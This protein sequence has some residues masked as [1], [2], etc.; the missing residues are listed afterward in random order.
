MTLTQAF[1]PPARQKHSSKNIANGFD[2]QIRANKS[3]Q[4]SN[5]R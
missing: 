3:H 5:G 1:S 4:L 2:F